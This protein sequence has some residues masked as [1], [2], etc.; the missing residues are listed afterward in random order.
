MKP[1]FFSLLSLILFA[2]AN[3]A[4]ASGEV[5]GDTED[6]VYYPGAS[7]SASARYRAPPKT[8]APLNALCSLAFLDRL[9]FKGVS[10]IPEKMNFCEIE[11]NKIPGD[12]ATVIEKIGEMNI[13]TAQSVGMK[14]KTLYPMTMNVFFQAN[15]LGA[16]GGSEVTGAGITL[17]VLPTWKVVDFSSMQYVHELVHVLNVN[18]G[19]FSEITG[20]VE[21]HPFLQEALPDLVSAV[22]HDST[23]IIVNDPGLPEC[24]RNFRDGTETYSLDKPYSSFYLVA[25]VDHLLECCAREKSLSP[26]AKRV[27]GAHEKIR[28]DS[29]TKIS[30]RRDELRLEFLEYTPKILE[31]PFQA[32]NCALKTITGLTFLDNC[33]THQ[34]GQPLT[35]FFFKLRKQTGRTQLLP[36][37]KQLHSLRARAIPYDCG[38]TSG[39]SRLG[40]A[41]AR[42]EFRPLLVAFVGLRESMSRDDQAKFDQV[43]NEHAMGKLMDLDRIYLNETFTGVAQARVGERNALYSKMQ[44]CDNP[45]KF[46]T[47]LCQVTCGRGE[48]LAPR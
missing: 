7:R 13:R 4:F 42:V 23:Q 29:L 35:S 26:Y 31:A 44:A 9:E 32:E 38:Y 46:D 12:V 27:C 8:F 19:P 22:V 36:F 14:P 24:I 28:L 30:N 17:M 18:S 45:F 39:S 2:I 21:N 1:N 40:G 15:A 37:L 5:P 16:L 43:W 41:R 34:F 11:A 3:Q 20:G 33:D 6:P 48:N 25:A 10:G 47:S